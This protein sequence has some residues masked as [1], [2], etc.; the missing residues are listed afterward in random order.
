V[1]ISRKIL[2]NDKKKPKKAFK[3]EKLRENIT[4][5]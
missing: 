5:M 2:K 1:K 4:G 3:L